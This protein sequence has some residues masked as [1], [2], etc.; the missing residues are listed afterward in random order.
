[1]DDLRKDD[2][3]RAR[4]TPLDEKV[5]QTF[6]LMELGIAMQRKKLRAQDPSASEEVIDERLYAWLAEPR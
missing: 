6:E 4:T 2:I 1:M 5:R 3:E